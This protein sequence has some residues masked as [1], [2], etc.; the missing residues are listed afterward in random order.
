M[1]QPFSFP[2]LPTYTPS[3]TP[4]N[5]C[6]M[7]S[8]DTS[9]ASLQ[10]DWCIFWAHELLLLEKFMGLL[11]TR[12]PTMP[13]RRS[14]SNFFM[15][16]SQETSDRAQLHLTKR[17][18]SIQQF[19]WFIHMPTDTVIIA[20]MTQSTLDEHTISFRVWESCPKQFNIKDIDAY[21]VILWEHSWDG[22]LSFFSPT[23]IHIYSFRTFYPL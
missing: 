17:Y 19:I 18:C 16:S 22:L 13:V 9:I 12:Q 4:H 8:K 23:Y 5:N 11:L 3:G 1:L 14:M 10:W 7:R 20:Q 21:I 15:R 2:L 6:T